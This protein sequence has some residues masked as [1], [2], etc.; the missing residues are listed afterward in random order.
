MDA[1]C[2]ACGER[3]AKAP[4]RLRWVVVVLAWIVAVPIGAVC[5]LVVPLNLVLMPSFL[6]VW[7]MAFGPLARWATDPICDGCRAD[8]RERHAAREAWVDRADCYARER[9]W[10]REPPPVVASG[11]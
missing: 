4:S 7:G 6:A 1:P 5:A 10:R 3:G 11:S 8:G 2:A 9:P